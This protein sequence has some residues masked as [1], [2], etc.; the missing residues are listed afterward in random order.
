MSEYKLQ[1]AIDVT[2]TCETLINNN[3]IELV[4]QLIGKKSEL[5]EKEVKAKYQNELVKKILKGN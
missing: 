3:Q 2:K 4:M 1:E 5:Y